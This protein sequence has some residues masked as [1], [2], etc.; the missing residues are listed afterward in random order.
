M[1]PRQRALV[2]SASLPFL[3]SQALAS[4]E[5]EYTLSPSQVT[6]T[7]TS[8]Q[9]QPTYAP[10]PAPSAPA[11]MPMPAPEQPQFGEI[12]YNTE[13]YMPEADTDASYTIQPYGAQTTIRPA[14]PAADIPAA[15]IPAPSFPAANGG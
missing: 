1:T 10:Q 6:P 13:P 9:P 5:N 14:V 4:A 2:L 3:A 15:V 8:Y 7:V 11:L 12:I